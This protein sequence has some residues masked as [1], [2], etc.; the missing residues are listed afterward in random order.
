MLSD[1]AFG[2]ASEL[3]G[4]LR[5]REVSSLE[6]V[7]LYIERIDRHDRELNAVV[8]RDFDRAR[9]KARALDAER[10]RGD[11]R[12]LLGLPITVKESFN[13][14]G[15]ENHLG[16][17]KIREQCFDLYG[18]SRRTPGACRG[19]PARQNECAPLPARVSNL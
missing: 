12:P 13:V 6:L 2:S 9:E 14:V 4:L 17:P 15:V 18:R 16:Q 10:G 1:L 19:Y 8:L 3:C 5:R 11:A 7:D